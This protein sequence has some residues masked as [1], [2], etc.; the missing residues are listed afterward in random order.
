GTISTGSSDKT[1]DMYVFPANMVTWFFGDGQFVNA[2]GSYYKHTDVGFLR[3]IYYFGL[4]G[5]FAYFIMQYKMVKYLKIIVPRGN[6][7]YMFMTIFV[8]IL[9]LNF[10]GIAYF[11]F[12]GTL[13]IVIA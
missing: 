9:I 10:K 7:R 11:D 3:L 8:W 6:F 12:F 5:T 2:D 1:L 4:I 13:F